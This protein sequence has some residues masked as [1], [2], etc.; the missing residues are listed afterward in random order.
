M[1]HE[2]Y[3]DIFST[4]PKAIM[5]LIGYEKILSDIEY[6][7]A[8]G[9][10]IF[11]EGPEGLGKTSILL[12]IIESFKGQR[13]VAYVD[14]QKLK[15][16]INIEKILI[17][18]YGTLGKLF[19]VLPK[20]MIVLL[21]NI[22]FLSRK[23]AERIKYFYDHNNIKS[24]VFTAPNFSNVDF[25]ESLKHRIGKRIIRLPKLNSNSASEILFSRIL[26]VDLMKAGT[27]NK[28]YSFSDYNPK[29]FLNNCILVFE[30]AEKEEKDE[31]TIKD[32]KHIIK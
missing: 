30:Y 22:E 3:S 23:N 15:K 26:E 11:V 7:V 28:L 31:I 29:H 32:L 17:N 9:S 20:D 18:K 1:E 10:L 6:L 19:K 24:V 13:K 5:P 2:Y 25:P 12:K 21:D 27:I 4:K 8:S 14:C 16:S